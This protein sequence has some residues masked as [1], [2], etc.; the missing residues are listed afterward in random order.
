[1]SSKTTAARVRQQMG[2]VDPATLITDHELRSSH[3]RSL[4]AMRAAPGSIDD[5]GTLAKSNPAIQLPPSISPRPIV[6]RTVLMTAAAAVLAGALVA[7][8]AVGLFWRAPINAEA[9]ATL[10]KAAHQTTSTSDPVLIP[11]Q[12]LKIDTKAIYSDQGDGGSGRLYWLETQNR[13][14]FVPANKSDPWIM[15]FEPTE[16]TTYFGQDTEA[17]VREIEARTPKA[18]T[19]RGIVQQSDPAWSEAELSA[20]PR[21]PDKLLEHIRHQSEPPA[22][23][24]DDQA[25]VWVADRLRAGTM[26]ADL[27]AALYRAAA[28]IPEVT[29]V[30]RE[31]V[32]DGRTGTAIGRIDHRSNSRHDIVIDPGTGQFIGERI[33]TLSGYGDI[34]PGTAIAWTAITTSVVT[35]APTPER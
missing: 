5:T 30:E 15:S 21:D 19:E 8:D 16:P 25:F 11:G 28:L 34:P 7:T 18:R 17:A 35:S 13:Q 12:Y 1:M 3:A 14:L 31:T 2:T 23:T 6:R 24:T 32:L 9:A 10:N 29:V 27:R 22:N 4:A 20:L 33:V 26:P